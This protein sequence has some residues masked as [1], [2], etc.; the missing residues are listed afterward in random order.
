MGSPDPA[1][2]AGSHA[3]FEGKLEGFRQAPFMWRP[4]GSD[5]SIALVVTY[6]PITGFIV[7][8][9]LDGS[10]RVTFYPAPFPAGS[11]KDRPE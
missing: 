2:L 5:E 10:H 11:G 8:R 6:H 3:G 7:Q 4:T 9:S 1:N